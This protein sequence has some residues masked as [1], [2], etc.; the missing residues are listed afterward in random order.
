MTAAAARAKLLEAFTSGSLLVNYLG[1]G[2]W[3]RLTANG[4]LGQADVAGLVSADTEPVLAAMTCDVGNFGLVGIDTLAENL[5]LKPDG[6]A[7][8]T[9]APTAMESNE[10]S[11]ALDAFFLPALFS[12]E[13]PPLGVA[14]QSALRS[15][16]GA[17]GAVTVLQSY[18]LLGDPALAVVP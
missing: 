17:G 16:A 12:A 14:T 7:I 2:A 18:A 15:Y 6:G 11:K 13:R 5:M 9:F 8:A 3:D 4:L 1:H 10:D